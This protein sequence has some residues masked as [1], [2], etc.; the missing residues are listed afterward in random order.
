[1]WQSNVQKAI[2]YK[3]PHL[4]CY[5]LT[6]EP[7][8][9]LAHMIAAG[10][11]LPP[12]D[13]HSADQFQYLIQ[14]TKEAE[15]Q[16]YEISNLALAGKFSKHNTNYWMGVSYLGIGPAAHSFD[17]LSRQWNIAHN[18]KYMDAIKAKDAGLLYQKE[19]LSAVDQSNEYILTSLRTMWGLDLEKIKLSAHRDQI[20]KAAEKYIREG[21]LLKKEEIFILSEQ[22]KFLADGIASELFVE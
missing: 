15:Y 11:T 14:S 10:K 2:A 21:M 12:N 16:H 19:V 6:V 17:G 9:A 8:T 1:M 13:S 7:K 3:I 5:A 22:A 20:E 18:K 4:S